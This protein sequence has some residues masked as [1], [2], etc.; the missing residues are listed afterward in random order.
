MMQSPKQEKLFQNH[1]EVVSEAGTKILK[2]W[3]CST[4]CLRPHLEE[5]VFFAKVACPCNY[6]E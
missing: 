5:K 3:F 1:K 6:S 4:G 2:N